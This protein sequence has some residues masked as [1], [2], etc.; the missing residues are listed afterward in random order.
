MARNATKKIARP[1]SDNDK[2]NFRFASSIEFTPVLAA[3][4]FFFGTL[5]AS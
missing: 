4:K 5:S 1:S 3:L 2:H